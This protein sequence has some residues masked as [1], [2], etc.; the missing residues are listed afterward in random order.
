ME[1]NEAS[2]Q[3]ESC[4]RSLASAGRI[5]NRKSCKPKNSGPACRP[6]TQSPG[7]KATPYDHQNPSRPFDRCELDADIKVHKKTP[8][9][10]PGAAFV[11]HST[12]KE[13]L[14]CPWQDWQRP[15]LPGLKP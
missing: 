15:T 6:G 9:P 3:A 4:G 5:L 2:Q 14:P 13:E 11:L 1:K 12:S 8:L 10:F 7:L